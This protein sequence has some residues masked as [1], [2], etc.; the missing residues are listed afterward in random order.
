MTPLKNAI[1]VE[2]RKNHDEA[3]A[4]SDDQLNKLLFHHPDGLRLSLKGF[5]V[6]KKIFTAYSFEL[7]DTI[8]SRHQFG[9]S[10]MEYPYF[11]TKKRL[12]LFSEMDAMVIKL[13]GGVQ[14]FLENYSQ[15][16]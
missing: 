11:F 8:R 3:N 6:I 2:V 13:H 5:V 12:I 7:P 14:G 4:L 1:F 10:K 16:D 15:I 9:M